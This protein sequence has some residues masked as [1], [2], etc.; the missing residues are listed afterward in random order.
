MVS[1]TVIVLVVVSAITAIVLLAGGGIVFFL[2]ASK[3]SLSNTPVEL[4]GLDSSGN[5]GRPAT[6]SLQESDP[7]EHSAVSSFPEE[8]NEAF[9]IEEISTA[10][11]SRDL[12]RSPR[13]TLLG[14]PQQ[15]IVL[16]LAPRGRT[17]D[18][19]QPDQMR[20][21][22]DRI[23][24]G[25]SQVLDTDQ[26]FFRKWPPQLSSEGFAH[27]FASQLP[28]PGD[29]GRGTPLTSVVGTINVPG[30]QLFVGMILRA[31]SA[32]QTGQF[33]VDSEGQWTEIL[34]IS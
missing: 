24:P 18:V 17:I 26:P 21:F 19:P 15:V 9:D 32:N 12:T 22:I 1:S 28:L 7:S 13:L 27:R 11:A 10:V 6:D 31:K 4:P 23:A 14:I 29:H 5:G 2:V 25:F 30:G 34:R 20:I 33:T 3:R 16:V 8:S